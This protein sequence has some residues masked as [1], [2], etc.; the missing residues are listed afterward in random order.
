MTTDDDRLVR[1]LGV[2]PALPDAGFTSDRVTRLSAVV[3]TLDV[4]VS[5]SVPVPCTH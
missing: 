5:V 4:A 1:M 3:S 2:T